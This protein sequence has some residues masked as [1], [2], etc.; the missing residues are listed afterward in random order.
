MAVV[1]SIYFII[2][3]LVVGHYAATHGRRFWVWWGLAII[4]PVLSVFILVLLPDTSPQGFMARR[5]RI[6]LRKKLHA[7]IPEQ[8]ML[9]VDFILKYHTPNREPQEPTEV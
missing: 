1:I 5:R 2:A 9:E 3:P 4:I 6:L 8:I 7:T